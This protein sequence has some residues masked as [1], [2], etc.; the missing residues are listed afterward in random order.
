MSNKNPTSFR[1]TE[2]ALSLLRKIADHQ[3]VQ[4]TDIIEILIREKA[5]KMGISVDTKGQNADI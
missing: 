3:G 2:V 5:T 4:K 1:L